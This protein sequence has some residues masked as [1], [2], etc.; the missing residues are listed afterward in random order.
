MGPHGPAPVADAP[1][2]IHRGRGSTV[3]SVELILELVL[4]ESVE[5]ADQDGAIGLGDR[6]MGL[7]LV[8]VAHVLFNWDF[9]DS[10]RFGGWNRFGGSFSLDRVRFGAVN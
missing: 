4:A 7:K 9:G 3:D 8:R 2:G 1:E 6:G 5:D 10:D